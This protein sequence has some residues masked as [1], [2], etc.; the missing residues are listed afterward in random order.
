MLWYIADQENV[1]KEQSSRAIEWRLI[2]ERAACF[3]GCH[4]RLISL[5]KQEL[6]KMCGTGLFSK[7]DFRDQLYEI[8]RVLNARPSVD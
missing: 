8:E 3:G 2:P 6:Y 7:E 5:L 1:K 4:E